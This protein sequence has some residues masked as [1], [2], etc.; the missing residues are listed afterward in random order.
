MDT[1]IHYLRRKTD[2]AIVLT[3]RGRGYRLGQP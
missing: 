1:Y 2:I 3:V